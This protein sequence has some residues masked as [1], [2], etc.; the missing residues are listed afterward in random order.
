MLTE[1]VSIPLMNKQRCVQIVR[2]TCTSTANHFP[3][4]KTFWVE[5]LP[6]GALTCK[7]PA[8]SKSIKMDFSS[9]SSHSHTLS[10]TLSLPL[11]INSTTKTKVYK[12]LVRF[13][14]PYIY[15]GHLLDVAV[16]TRHVSKDRQSG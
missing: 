8:A 6:L 3:S 10:L 7:L 16:L 1:P 9:F 11:P 14:Q 13:G 4:K 2:S 15:F 12:P 5:S